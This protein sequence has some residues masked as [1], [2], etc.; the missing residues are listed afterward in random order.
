MDK[1]TPFQALLLC[2]ERA[3]SDSQLARDLD[4]PQ[5]TMWRI[6]NR[7][8]QMPAEYVLKAER[9]YGVSRHEQRPDIYPCDYPPAA[10]VCAANDDSHRL[11][12]VSK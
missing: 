12:A 2:R 1:T 3:G 9:L 10:E 8:M 5:S 7:S 4:I 6:I 11:S